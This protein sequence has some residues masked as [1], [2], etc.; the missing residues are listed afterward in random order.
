MPEW[1]CVEITYL[2]NKSLK[3]AKIRSLSTNAIVY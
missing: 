1:S 3:G 2:G